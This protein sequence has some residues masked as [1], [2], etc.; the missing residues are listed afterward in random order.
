[1]AFQLKNKNSVLNNK[2]KNQMK[3]HTKLLKYLYESYSPLRKQQNKFKKK[4][5]KN[6]H[7]PTPDMSIW[8]FRTK[9]FVLLA[10]L[11]HSSFTYIT[12]IL[13]EKYLRCHLL[14]LF[15]VSY[16]LNK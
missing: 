7:T 1:M 3:Y 9:L 12:A 10:S 5:N 11:H 6:L 15:Q 13:E 14:L 8:L 4:K 16:E 2:R